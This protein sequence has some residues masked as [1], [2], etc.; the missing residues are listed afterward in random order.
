M[1]EDGV[2]CISKGR[3]GTSRYFKQDMTMLVDIMYK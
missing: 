2:Y 1:Y 3:L